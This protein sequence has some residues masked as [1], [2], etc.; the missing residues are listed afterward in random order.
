MKAT[1]AQDFAAGDVVALPVDS[2]EEEAAY[3]AEAPLLWLR[4]GF[5]ACP[6]NRREKSTAKES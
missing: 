1:T 3:I 6:L 2:P 5:E 4:S